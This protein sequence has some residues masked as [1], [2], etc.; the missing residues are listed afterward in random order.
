M[1]D[2]LAPVIEGYDLSGI[3][4]KYSFRCAPFYVEGDNDVTLLDGTTVHDTLAAKV[5]LSWTLNALSAQ[6]YAD[7]S[8]ALRSGP[9]PDTVD[10]YVFDPTRNLNIFARFHVS[11]PE[12]LY[13]VDAPAPMSFADTELVLEEAKSSGQFAFTPPNKLAYKRGESLDLT[14]LTVTQYNENGNGID[15]T[16]QCNF[17]PANGTMLLIEGTIPVIVTLPSGFELPIGCN[18]TVTSPITIVSGDWWT[19]Y[20]NG[21]LYIYCDGDIPDYTN[22][23][24]SSISPW[25]YYRRQIFSVAMENS[26]TAI[27]NKAF[28]DCLYITGVTIGN[29]V[30]RIG[31]RAFTSCDRLTSVTIPDSVTTIGYSAFHDC[32][33]LTSVTISNSVTTIGERTFAKCS[34]L[35]SV[36]IPDGVTTIGEAAF[37]LCSR[38]SNVTIPNSVTA[39]K[40]N[41]FSNCSSLA[42]VYYS[43]TEGQR[44]AM[45]IIDGNRWLLN[46]TWHYNSTGP[47]S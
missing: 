6:Q 23:S 16:A 37:W 13:A 43:G 25:R 12:W 44:A 27:G 31:T 28:E 17:S 1:R 47:D 4:N 30:T 26:V 18:I 34:R 29:R 5:R 42:H 32:T 38:L 45:T 46:A 33:N 9:S 22:T 41:A 21:L 35:T 3:V 10:A 39:I 2:P 36:T 40:I 8:A 24:A 15:I 11:A 20:D 7:L 14:G 19:L